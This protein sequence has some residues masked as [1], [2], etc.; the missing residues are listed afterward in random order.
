M[1]PDRLTFGAGY[2]RI[3]QSWGNVQI[4]RLVKC[5][6]NAPRPKPCKAQTLHRSPKRL[7]ANNGFVLDDRHFFG[8]D[9]NN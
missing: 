7:R 5:R 4:R 6:S 9:I 1:Y 3:L 8:E 2:A